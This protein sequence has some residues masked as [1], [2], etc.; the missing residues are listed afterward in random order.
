M[1]NLFNEFEPVSL[2]EWTEKIVAD[3]KG[4]ELSVLDFKDPVE[5]IDFRA[6]YHEENQKPNELTPGSFPATR[7][8]RTQ[9]NDWH[10]GALIHVNN[11]KEAN[12]EALKALMRGA[13]LL[14]FTTERPTDWSLILEGVQLEYIKAQFQIQSTSEAE[15]LMKI[16]GNAKSNISFCFDALEVGN[17]EDLIALQSNEQIATFVVNGFGVQQCG[18][19]SSQEVAF[20]L[21]TG[22]EALIKIMATGKTIDEAAAMI[23]FHLGVG[24]QYFNEI[25][26]FRALRMLW[27]KIID[28]YQPKHECSYNCQITSIVGHT[29]KSLKDPYTN[30]LRQTTETM[31]AT[32]GS[33]SIIVLPYDL[34]SANGPSELARRMALNMSLILKEESYL[35]HV[36][37]PA[38]GSYSIE[39]LTDEVSKKAWTLFQ[40]ME[41]AGGISEKSVLDSFKSKVAEKRALRERL[42]SEGKRTLIGIN[43]FE[44]PKAKTDVW[45]KTPGY[46]GMEVFIAELTQKETTV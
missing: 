32:N 23:H 8:S 22:H 4:K 9:N 21:A 38:G 33:D 37:D 31:S 5:E 3:L 40:E 11:E 16:A 18:A 30:L 41:G 1:G 34:L 43:K 6:F 2:A 25:A 13:D 42:V 44:D 15:V 17:H 45:T 36:I 20:C 35:H 27:S 29:N 46:L 10:N 24:S 26:K 14:Y 28:A 19:N 39:H 7:G 12:K